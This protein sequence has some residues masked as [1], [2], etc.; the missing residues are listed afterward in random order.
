MSGSEQKVKQSQQ[1]NQTKENKIIGKTYHS[2]NIGPINNDFSIPTKIK[3]PFDDKADEF[4]QNIKNI[5]E[6][7]FSKNPP[8][9]FPIQNFSLLSNYVSSEQRKKICDFILSY[10]TNVASTYS[11]ELL[12]LS[13]NSEIIIKSGQ[14]IS[15]ILNFSNFFGFIQLDQSFSE[16]Y[17]KTL[18]ANMYYNNDAFLGL[19]SSIVSEILVNSLKANKPLARDEQYIILLTE[20]ANLFTDNFIRTITQHLSIFFKNIMSQGNEND[21]NSMKTQYCAAFKSFYTLYSSLPDTTVNFLKLI[22][23][24]FSNEVIHQNAVQ[25]IISVG[26]VVFY[27]QD[28]INAFFAV[29]DPAT[30]ITDYALFVKSMISNG[31]DMQKMANLHRF[32][33]KQ[34]IHM[35]HIVERFLKKRLK[36]NEKQAIVSFAELLDNE[37]RSGKYSPD[38]IS[39]LSLIQDKFGFES[40]HSALMM[41]RA[42]ETDFELDKRFAEEYNDFFNDNHSENFMLICKDV[43]E[44]RSLFK[45][46]LKEKK[47]VPS[48]LSIFVFFWQNWKIDDYAKYKFPDIILPHLTNFTLYMRKVCPKKQLSWHLAASDCKLKIGKFLISCNGVTGAVLLTLNDSPKTVDQIKNLLTISDFDPEPILSQFMEK[49][50]GNIINRFIERGQTFYKIN[51][52]IDLNDGDE[53]TIKTLLTLPE[54]I[55]KSQNGRYDFFNIASK[56]TQIDGLIMSSLKGKEMTKQQILS[57]I[58]KMVTFPIEEN[59]IQE[60]IDRLE[61]RNFITHDPVN[62]NVFRYVP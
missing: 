12:S 14:I 28:Q 36:E 7:S 20:N 45:N 24:I 40:V 13:E 37:F 42:I 4:E 29:I 62:E 44:S 9:S 56:T 32:I 54:D 43:E 59:F 57:R 33:G 2:I 39:E 47:E 52:D 17:Y 3:S 23:K 55:N 19:F 41:R 49:K 51:T 26:E 38:I 10:I 31:I 16:I 27:N 15:T 58:Q 30:P 53:V 11:Q 50:G 22:S 61:R 35:R 18:H 60:R 6:P 1:E 21:K 46:F 34:S 25:F 5:I 48:F 8:N